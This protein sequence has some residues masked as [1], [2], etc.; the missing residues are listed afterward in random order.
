MSM[1]VVAALSG[2]GTGPGVEVRSA[3]PEGTLVQAQENSSALLADP[4]KVTGVLIR[5][6]T[7]GTVNVGPVGPTSTMT[8]CELIALTGNP[9]ATMA[10][11][12]LIA[13]TGT[14][15]STMAVCEL[16]A[17]TG[18]PVSTTPVIALI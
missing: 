13:L 4:S 8:V 6:T 2:Y 14:T 11:C 12:E 18:V 17:L 5:P 1:G 9:T 16:I 3:D 7:F 15:A 10:V